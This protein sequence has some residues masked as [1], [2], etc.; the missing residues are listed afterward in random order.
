VARIGR[1]NLILTVLTIAGVLASSV[2]LIDGLRTSQSAA[3][4]LPAAAV[5]PSGCVRPAG[6]FLIIAS[7]YGYN[8]SVLEGA[9]PSKAWPVISVTQG[10]TV[11]ITVCNVDPTE[12]HGFQVSNYYDSKI[13]SIAPGQVV[14]VSFIASRAGSF[15]I[16]CAIFCAIHLFMEYGLLRVSS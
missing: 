9:G 4:A 7:Q 5:L 8:D 12:S 14:N 13:V 11:N 1:T 2:V 10:Q 3:T 16:Y 15:P 6:G